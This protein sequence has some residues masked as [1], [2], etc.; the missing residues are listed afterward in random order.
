LQFAVVTLAAERLRVAEA[1]FEDALDSG[2]GVDAA[3][4]AEVHEAVLELIWATGTKDLASALAATM[5]PN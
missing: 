2:K 5:D 1:A 3:T 4:L